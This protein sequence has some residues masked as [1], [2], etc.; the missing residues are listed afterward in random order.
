MNKNKYE[1]NCKVSALY[2][3]SI[4][5]LNVR[6]LNLPQELCNEKTKFFHKCEDGRLTILIKNSEMNFRENFTVFFSKSLRVDFKNPQ[7]I[8]K[9]KE[10][11]LRYLVTKDLLSNDA[12][13]DKINGSDF[14]ISECLSSELV[15][16]DVKEII[17]LNCDNPLVKFGMD[18]TGNKVIY[19]FNYDYFGNLEMLSCHESHIENI[20]PNLDEKLKTM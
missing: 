8:I 14:H 18:A 6:V 4:G 3:N 7:I 19:N 11:N 10:F 13:L 15:W 20:I 5:L 16:Y 12:I 1:I 9:D 2:Y 17:C